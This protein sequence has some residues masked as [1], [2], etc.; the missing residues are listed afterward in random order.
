VNLSGAWVTTNHTVTRAGYVFVLP[1][2]RACQSGTQQECDAWLAGQHLRQV[3][4]YQP[5]SRFWAL[6]RDET[7]IFVAAA[8]V[9]TG[10]CYWRVRRL[11]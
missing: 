3:I 9:M 1:L 10:L 6:Q 8:I 7:G 4:A 5:A 11:R 2:V